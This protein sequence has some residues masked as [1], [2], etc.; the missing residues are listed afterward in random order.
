MSHTIRLSDAYTD[1]VVGQISDA[2]ACITGEEPVS[3][4]APAFSEIAPPEWGDYWRVELEPCRYVNETESRADVEVCSPGDATFW[5]VYGR[6]FDGTAEVI[7]YDESPTNA[8][9][10]AAWCMQQ[11]AD[12]LA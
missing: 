1:E 6:R 5:S 4:G 12:A 10:V 9:Q 7:H 2:I 8:L 11:V 3:V